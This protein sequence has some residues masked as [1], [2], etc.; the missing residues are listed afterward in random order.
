MEQWT[1]WAERTSEPCTWGDFASR[2][3]DKPVLERSESWRSW[4]TAKVHKP[5]SRDPWYLWADVARK[6]LELRGKDR[7]RTRSPE[8]VARM[9]S[10]AEKT[11]DQA[12]R[13][14]LQRCSRDKWLAQMTDW[15]RWA[16][17]VRTNSN[18]RAMVQ[19]AED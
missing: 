13:F 1:E 3:A 6:C 14:M 18:R 11:W 15:H 2:N 17:S 7:K 19:D 10:P 16:D 8:R 4:A 5:Q 9:T 12:I